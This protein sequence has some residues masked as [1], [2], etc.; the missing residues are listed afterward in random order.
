MLLPQES[1]PGGDAA[2]DASDSP[3]PGTGPRAVNRVLPARADASAYP[4]APQTI[5]FNNPGAQTF[6]TTPTLVAS[7]DSGLPLRHRR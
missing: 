6:G 5:T 1:A 4:A 7:V 2:S 3:G